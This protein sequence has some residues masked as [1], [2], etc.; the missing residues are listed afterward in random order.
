MPNCSLIPL[1]GFVINN[2][3]KLIHCSNKWLLPKLKTKEITFNFW[4]LTSVHVRGGDVRNFSEILLLF[5][6]MNTFAS[7][8]CTRYHFISDG[9]LNSAGLLT[10]YC[11]K[12][13]ERWTWSQQHIISQQRTIVLPNICQQ[14]KGTSKN[15]KRVLRLKLSYRR[16]HTDYRYHKRCRTREKRRSSNYIILQNAEVKGYLTFRFLFDSKTR[17]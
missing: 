17:L 15:G 3:K 12:L 16:W 13:N 2:C 14:T 4:S 5:L 10:L 11:F 7:S 6:N 1:V 9:R 8:S